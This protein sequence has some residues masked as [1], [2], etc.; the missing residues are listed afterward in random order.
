MSK[1]KTKKKSSKKV[2]V[3]SYR[4]GSATRKNIPTAKIAAE[5]TVPRVAK[6]KYAY[7]AHLSPELRFDASGKCDR[8]TEIVEKAAAGNKL[9]REEVDILRGVAANAS[10]P[11]LEWSGKKEE[12]D[13]GVLEVEPVALHIHERVSA[14]AIVRA[15]KREDT[16][17]DLF[18]DPKQEYKEAI[19]FYKHDVDWANRLILG[20]SLEVMA[21]L[22]RREDLA[23]KI[24]MIYMDPP[25]GIKFASNFQSQL[26]DRNVKDQDKDITREPEM[27]KAYRDTWRLGTHSYLSYLRD[28]L[29][30][31]KELLSDAGSI[32]V[33]ISD[34]NLHRVRAILDEVFGPQNFQSIITY[35]SSVPLKST[36]L[37]SIGDYVIWYAKN[38]DKMKRHD[39][40]LERANNPS[41]MAN[42]VEDLTGL[43]RPLTEE[44]K[45]NPESIPEGSRVFA[46]DNLVSSGYTAT[47]I[48][49]I[50]YQGKTYA[51]R[52][53]KSWKT[54]PEGMARLLEAERV[55]ASGK[56]LRAMSYVDD[57]PVQKLSNF[58]TDTTGA[59]DKK[60][61]VETPTKVIPRCL[62][63]TT[64]PG[65][66]VLDPTCGSG[67]T[68]YVAEQWGRR[69]I[70]VDSSRV[71]ISL[72]RQ[73]LLTARYDS[74]ELR[75]KD[76][77]HKRASDP[78]SNF[79]YRQVP[80]VTLGSIAR[81]GNLDPIFD[82]HESRLKDALQAVNL[83]MRD[84]EDDLRQSLAFKLGEKLQA[85]GLRS[86]T[87]ADKRRWLLPGVTEEM[88]K[89]A[90]DGKQKLKPKHVSE[91]LSLVP[92]GGSF[93]LWEVPFDTDPNWPESLQVAVDEFRELYRYR[94]SEINACIN[95]NSDQE[96]LVDQ[97]IRIPNAVRVSGPFTVE[98]V[99]PE[100]L[101]LSEDGELFDPTP[102]EFEINDGQGEYAQNASA[103]L[104]RMMRLISQGGVTF[105]NNEHREFALVERLEES[106]SALHAEALWEGAD[107]EGGPNIGI[108][109]GPQHGPVTASQVEDLVRASRRY[110]ELVIAAFSFDGSSQAVIQESANP[111][112]KI[113]MVHIRP[114]VSPGMDGLLK[115][116]PKS[117]LFTVFGQP[118]IK[119]HEEDSAIKVELLG[120]DIYS[121]LTGEITSSGANKVAAWFLDSDYDGR[122]FCITQ[123]FFPNQKAWDKIAKALGSSADSEAF[124]AFNGTVS[125]P[126][127]SG[128]HKRIAVKVIDPRGN[129]VMAIRNLKDAN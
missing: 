104:D 1:K 54:N 23:G 125:V 91:Y 90:F 120:V 13:R 15:A 60:Y 103:Y 35:R 21:S 31:A 88:L 25:Y 9:N 89:R 100:E 22:A 52:S 44:E 43:R 81:N 114:D 38:S 112:L 24:Q 6:A 76:E 111:R 42:Y 56:T 79:V 117:Q 113:H 30:L 8:V 108:A 71:A 69:W 65:D 14:N 12:H 7:S 59:P 116:S 66:L 96:E 105:P 41:S 118:E 48:F 83:A 122:C 85:K 58:W 95:A 84:V 93:D 32:F 50:K 123:A 17:V 34:E 74:Y 39:L 27:I 51:A 70:T 46:T 129:E 36:G 18:A 121:P 110:D 63:M 68:G 5:G 45:T 40:Y 47:C 49:D 77:N 16:Q 94:M 102:N 26:G 78:K 29:L 86:A 99:R 128:V 82:K 119:L 92:S 37:P 67:T 57:Y 3:E 53:G 75:D 87:N 72:A 10:Q 97:P 73:R 19:Q 124:E 80:H 126:F 115:D 127:E 62:L 33:Q 2:A 61:V 64:D 11:W 28:R 101:L 106:D 109:F 4:H 20:D 107:C 98:G 55:S